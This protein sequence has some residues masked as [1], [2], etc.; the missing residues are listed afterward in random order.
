MNH[1]CLSRQSAVLLPEIFS[2]N[3]LGVEHVVHA[4]VKFPADVVGLSNFHCHFVLA[5]VFDFVEGFLQVDFLVQLL[6][7]VLLE[8]LTL[9]L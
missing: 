2:Y 8:V 6:L 1:F 7:G 4:V 3:Y 5:L 9:D